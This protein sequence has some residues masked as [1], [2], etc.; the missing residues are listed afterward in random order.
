MRTTES[1]FLALVF[2]ACLVPAVFSMLSTYVLA[3][4]DGRHVE[5]QDAVYA[6]SVWLILGSLTPV[7]YFFAKYFPLRRHRWPGTLV[8]HILGVAGLC[9]IW[10]V[11][12]I[13]LGVVLQHHTNSPRLLPPGSYL[14]VFTGWALS[15]IPWALFAYTAVLGSVYAFSYFTKAKEQQTRALRL[16]GQLSEARLSALRGQLNP[17]FLFNSL[18]TVLVLVREKDTAAA[19]RVIE[20]LADVL[21]QTLKA[22]S[23][24]EVTL[25]EELQFLRRY[26][27]IEQVRFSDRLDV[28]WHIDDRAQPAL[29]PSF[30]M[31]PI[32][33]NAIKHGITKRAGSG[34]IEIGAQV[35]DS[36]LELKVCDDGIGPHPSWQGGIGLSNTRERLRV[37]Y[38]DRADFT[39]GT[40]SNGGAEVTLILPFRV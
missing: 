10:G 37:M 15:S 6:G 26:L 30:I 19:S 5:W 2:A 32:V 3:H 11:L 8:A 36:S 23:Q 13:G 31:Q 18:N 29:V 39:I 34:K 35:R 22:D 33:E 9:A 25:H 14:R 24:L 12:S 1:L 4:V 21:R 38:G 27:A 7:T 28:Q 17:H 16:E 40:S 20:L